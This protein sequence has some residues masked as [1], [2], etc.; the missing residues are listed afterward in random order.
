MRRESQRS[1]LVVAT[2]MLLG[3]S[4]ASTPGP[5]KLEASADKA[6]GLTEK[7]CEQLGADPDCDVCE[8]SGWYGDGLCD[9]FCDVFDYQDCAVD[10]CPE[11]AAAYQAC[12]ADGGSVDGCIG[13]DLVLAQECCELGPQPYCADLSLRPSAGDCAALDDQLVACVA[14]GD[15]E[16]ACYQ[17]LSPPDANSALLC[18]SDFPASLSAC[19]TIVAIEECTLVNHD[20]VS[21][22]FDAM[23]DN[24]LTRE[25][26]ESACANDLA[27]VLDDLGCCES[28]LEIPVCDSLP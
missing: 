21:C 22:V 12:T 11:L 1:T 24:G 23:G 25:Q 26:A 17:E 3:C 28:N 2:L 19:P 7:I 8:E 27:N 6:D 10:D 14:G 13:P 20:W 4:S 16:L 5:S 9:G 18:C 15:D